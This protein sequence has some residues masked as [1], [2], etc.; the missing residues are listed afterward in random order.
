[1][2]EEKKPRFVLNSLDDLFTTQ[3]MRD[4]AKLANIINI[5]D[6]QMSY[7][8]DVSPG[9]GLIKVGSA[10]VPFENKFPKNTKLYQLMSTKPGEA[11]YGK[12]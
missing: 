4:E 7:I 8:I 1:M 11:V 10:L 12:D 6:E 3:E 9:C 2:S 5:S